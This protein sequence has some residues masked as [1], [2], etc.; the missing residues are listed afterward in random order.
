[1]DRPIWQILFA[2]SFAAFVAAG[3]GVG[4]VFYSEEGGPSYLPILYA[5]QGAAA[6]AT[7]LGALLDRKWASSAAVAAGAFF[8][9]S[10]FL[11]SIA[12][13]AAVSGFGGL[14]IIA[15]VTASI[16]WML[17]GSPPQS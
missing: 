5:V 14:L 15:L 16:S 7:M 17:R 1:M 13:G 6:L 11:R 12:E 8:A 4:C 2:L 3:A 10:T 9:T